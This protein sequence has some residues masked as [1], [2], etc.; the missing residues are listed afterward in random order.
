MRDSWACIMVSEA[1]DLE[2]LNA[3]RRFTAMASLSDQPLRGIPQ[4]RSATNSNSNTGPGWYRATR[5]LSCASNS[6]ALG[7]IHSRD[8]PWREWKDA[9][10]IH[11]VKTFRRDDE[12]IP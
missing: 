1:A 9:I 3:D 12:G 8:N 4:T 5:A 10:P 6:I 2:S 7:P 11:P